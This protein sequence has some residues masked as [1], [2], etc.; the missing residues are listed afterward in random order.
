MKLG[1]IEM[2][3]KDIMIRQSHPM[4][5]ANSEPPL[6]EQ[7]TSS[8]GSSA[9]DF[10]KPTSNQD[11]SSSGKREKDTLSKSHRIGKDS[12]QVANTR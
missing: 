2:T 12:S 3:S 1:I 4:F 6:I 11:G 10:G 9:P 5:K 7:R 8:S